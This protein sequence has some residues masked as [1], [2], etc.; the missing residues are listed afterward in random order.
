MNV[1]LEVA[2]CSLLEIYRRFRDVT[3]RKKCL[4]YMKFSM[5]FYGKMT[6]FKINH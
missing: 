6:E 2:T 4:G 3:F 5:L 1:F